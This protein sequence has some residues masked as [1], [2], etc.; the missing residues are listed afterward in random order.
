MN[1]KLK[2]LN[3]KG[4]RYTYTEEQV[5]DKSWLQIFHM[6]FKSI[7]AYLIYEK[8]CKWLHFLVS[9]LCDIEMCLK[10]LKD[11]ELQYNVEGCNILNPNTKTTKAEDNIP[12]K[13][14]YCN[15][16]IY[17]GYSRVAGF[18]LGTH[19]YGYCY[20]LG[21]G[22]YSFLNSTELLWDGCKECGI[23]EDMEIGDEDE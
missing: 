15:G 3:F 20:Y 12:K 1:L 13:D 2:F 10:Y 5:K 4:D 22:D 6:K 17:S 16:C 11:K 19:S 9:T 23:N 18:F 21:K 14:F 7:V 8:D